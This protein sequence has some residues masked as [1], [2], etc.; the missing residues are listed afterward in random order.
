ME[1]I[2]NVNI[3]EIAMI[4]RDYLVSADLIDLM[5]GKEVPTIKE[6]IAL[7]EDEIEQGVEDDCD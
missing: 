6:M 2:E 7:L 1:V 3:G 5:S 4:M